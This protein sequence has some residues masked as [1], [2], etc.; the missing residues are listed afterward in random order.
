MKHLKV[1]FLLSII[2]L[3]YINAKGQTYV[4]NVVGFNLVSANKVTVALNTTTTTVK[5]EVVCSR[6]SDGV[7]PGT[8]TVVWKPFKMNFKL[9]V[10]NTNGS[11]EVLPDVYTM[12]DGDFTRENPGINNKQFTAV[13]SNNKL[14][15][16]GYIYI[17]FNIPSVNNGVTYQGYSV[18][19]SNRY[20]IVVA[21]PVVPDPSPATLAKIASMGFNTSGIK[22][23]STYYVVENDIRLSKNALA[24]TSNTNYTVGNTYSHNVNILIDESVWGNGR[25]YNDLLE[26]LR[27]WNSGPNSDI[28]LNLIYD[29]FKYTVSPRID[30]SIKGS[31][32]ITT[33]T[34][35]QFPDGFGGP[36][37]LITV[38][39]NF[40]SPT[41][42]NVLN[43]VHAIGHSLGLKHTP[44]TATGYQ[45]SVM[46]P[47]NATVSVWSVLLEN[48]GL[49][50][51]YDVSN[52]ST[53]YPGNAGSII[54][55]YINGPGS[56]N[57][58]ASVT[59]RM[60]Y[61][62]S[63]AGINYHWKVIGINGTTY[64]YEPSENNAALYDF[65]LPN[66]GTYQLQCTISGGK[67]TT[68]VTSTKN[69]TVL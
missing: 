62:S 55:A 16:N 69:I 33:A 48:Y 68:P 57:A 3:A 34:E 42:D 58:S 1:L 35:T 60:S 67:Y 12:T 54:N 6:V 30:I 5:F 23:F 59:Y 24:Q 39:S 52:I 26:A 21:S 10:Q 17:Q 41:N 14:P 40:T 9:V 25:W 65:G 29:Y 66:A 22:T 2:S 46:K 11:R 38:N 8:T 47:G 13:I 37:A 53:N 61:I 43:M 28:K 51:T 36:G 31:S 18:Y 32:S 15:N 4:G 63:E 49:P 20:P 44:S 56:F 19:E 64:L 7:T 45:N 27:V 50:S